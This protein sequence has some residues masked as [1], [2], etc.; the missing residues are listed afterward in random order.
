M[1]VG[2]TVRGV[3]VCVCVHA[4][5]AFVLSVRPFFVTLH[6]FSSL[7]HFL[8]LRKDYFFFFYILLIVPLFYIVKITPMSKNA[9]NVFL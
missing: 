6:S 1:G 3:C 9:I 2:R 5:A 8:Y 7:P 4:H